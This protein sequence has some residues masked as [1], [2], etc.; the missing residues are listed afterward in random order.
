M[1]NLLSALNDLKIQANGTD[2]GAI[3]N[4][5]LANP[6]CAGIVFDFPTGA[7]ITVSTNI[8]GNH[9]ILRFCSGN[10]LTGGA[11]IQNVLYQFNNARSK[12]FDLSINHSNVTV[13]TPYLSVAVF[14][15]VADGVTDDQP[16]L[17][18]ASDTSIANP[19]LPRDLWLPNGWG[20]QSNSYYIAR[21]WNLWNWTGEIYQQFNITILGNRG[22]QGS[23][24]NG[25]AR[26]KFTY[27]DSYGIGVFRACG[28]AIR[29]IS[30]EGPWTCNVS[31][32]VFYQS[33]WAEL[34]P[35]MAD[36]LTNP[37]AC[38]VIDPATDRSAVAAGAGY[39]IQINADGT[40]TDISRGGVVTSGT[41]WFNI[42]E[43]VVQ[44]A[45]VGILNS[46]NLNTQQGEDCT[47]REVQ[48]NFCKVAVAYCQRQSD[49]TAIRTLR[50]WYYVQTGIDTM[51]YGNQE[52]TVSIIDGLNMGECVFQ[53]FNITVQKTLAIRNVYSE[54][55][56]QIGTLIGPY[57]GILLQGNFEL[58]ISPTNIQPQ[59]HFN[60]R[61]V[62][63][64]NSCFRYYDDQFNKRMR[65]LAS[66]IS[67]KNTFLD[68]PPL[69][70]NEFA[71]GGINCRY[72]DCVVGSNL[73]LGTHND[74]GYFSSLNRYPILYGKFTLQDNYTSIG[75]T[76]KYKYDCTTFNRYINNIFS[77]AVQIT[78]DA[79]RSC[80]ITLPTNFQ[81]S[82]QVNDYLIDASTQNVLGRIS[83]V[84]TTS[85]TISEIPVNI[86]SNTYNCNL[87]YFN[88]VT[89][90][91]FIGDLTAG[92]NTIENVYVTGYAAPLVGL[93]YEH[94]A[95]PP[96]TY[97]TAYNATANT[98]TL[99][100]SATKTMTKQNFINGTP[101]ITIEA[102]MAPNENEGYTKAILSGTVWYDSLT[103][104]VKN[105]WIF[106]RGGFL[107]ASAVKMPGASQADYYI[108]TNKRINDGIQYY[109]TSTGV[110]VQ[111]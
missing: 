60:F 92:S 4:T 20:G 11:T 69:I 111:T 13:D 79:N 22:V 25:F 82:L 65:G 17:Q 2:Q 52:G 100:L 27:T 62:E 57:T 23:P 31:T 93:R 49:R 53:L 95:L 10:N 19:T 72:E 16:A 54:A 109:N 80:V 107:N 86:V 75:G 5:A 26:I 37:S 78:P 21:P 81:Y 99:S 110:W 8:V 94:P 87:I 96:T 106:N 50:S 15:T 101:E 39:P 55:A 83:A 45:T 46:P 38:I 40:T 90:G 104:P 47:I 68:A 24:L 35:N 43:C 74:V 14:G 73:S 84:S 48:A 91:N 105:K 18:K 28:G 85:L 44:G 98:V 3:I 7:E 34:A 66:N 6:T 12:A 32:D 36:G 88:I 42:E 77:S 97:I 76:L 63:M 58:Y 33:T 108:E 9:K 41:T 1:S 67:F 29:G 71:T 51:T 103:N 56:F 61:N 64:S 59:N 30:V 102:N 89:T 70:Q